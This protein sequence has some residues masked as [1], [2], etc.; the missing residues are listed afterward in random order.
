M[1]STY[2]FLNSI[3]YIDSAFYSC[4]NTL[5]GQ[6]GLIQIAKIIS[7]MLQN[8]N[9]TNKFETQNDYSIGCIRKIYGLKLE[10]ILTAEEVAL[11]EINAVTDDPLI[12][13]NEQILK[14]VD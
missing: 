9:F 2:L 6:E 14:D 4:I 13:K 12:F 8:S 3:K 11:N 10:Q 5:R 1:L 7:E